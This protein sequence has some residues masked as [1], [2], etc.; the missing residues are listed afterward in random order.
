M[1]TPIGFEFEFEFQR[2][3]CN[4]LHALRMKIY[5]TAFPF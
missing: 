1:Q 5:P 4:Q 2:Q 3:I